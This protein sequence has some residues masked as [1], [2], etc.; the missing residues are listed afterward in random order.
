MDQREAVHHV[1]DLVALQRPDQVPL[2]RDVGAGILFCQRLLH[3]VFSDDVESGRRSS[4]HRLG[5][6]ALRHRDDAHAM[7][8][9]ANLLAPGDFGAYGSQAA[10]KGG[11]RHNPQI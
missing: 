4:P 1:A 9:A 3:P 7:R 5:T 8:P 11:I 6:V 10:G 2:D